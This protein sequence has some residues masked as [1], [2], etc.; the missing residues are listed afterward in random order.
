MMSYFK[1]LRF[2]NL[3]F[4]A[5]AVAFVA[6]LPITRNGFVDWDDTAVLLD[7]PRYRGLG[8][9]EISWMF[10]TLHMSLYRP[11]TWVTFGLDYLLW[12]VNPAGYHLTS[13][14][15]HAVNAA[16]VYLIA[17][18]LLTF[19]HKDE[20]RGALSLA[21]GLSALVFALHP[22][23]VEA[24]AWSSARSEP[25]AAFFIFLSLICYLRNAENYSWWTL[26]AALTFYALSLLSKSS[27]VTFPFVLLALD[28]YP[29]RRLKG[30]PF[31]SSA[32]T[33]WLEKAPFFVLSV[34][35]AAIA[36][37]AKRA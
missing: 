23:R 22:L 3:A 2:L 31:T 36:V 19:V 35:A 18:R 9:T 15:F 32:S 16:L 27:G 30:S 21:A 14:L 20:S 28:F 29:L 26:V 1:R 4:F 37:V 11:I 12:G 13:L 5:A 17:V 8:W 33:V 34:A 6:F 25:V 10:T 24:V 7:N